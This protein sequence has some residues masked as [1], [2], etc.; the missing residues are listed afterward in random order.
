MANNVL[1]LSQLVGLFG[2]GAMLDLP[3]RSVLVLGLDHW[4]MN[5]KDTFRVIEERRLSQLLEERLGRD[6][7]IGQGKKLTLRTPPVD[8]GIYQG[9]FV[10]GV[11]VTT[12]PTWFVCEAVAAP[13][14]SEA[15]PEGARRRRVVRWTDLDPKGRKKFR[16]EASGKAQEVTPL[17][18]VCCCQKGHLQDINWRWVVHADE[19]CTEPMWLEETGTSADPRDTSRLPAGGSSTY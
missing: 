19:T 18:F 10:P 6:G 3:E 13:G 1:R 12:F 5:G 4:E 17:R 11:A 16:D 7:R 14:N 8:P 9:A 15:N 2:P